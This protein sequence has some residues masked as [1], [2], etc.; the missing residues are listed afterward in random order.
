MGTYSQATGGTKH[1]VIDPGVRAYWSRERA[2]HGEKV[3]LSV[4]ARH[5]KDGTKVVVEIR[6]DGA[7]PSSPP[8]ATLDKGY[9]LQKGKCAI[10]YTIKWDKASLGKELELETDACLFYFVAKMDD[11]EIAQ[12]SENLLYVHLE[13]VVSG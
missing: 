4:E 13:Y 7:D 11:L 1:I 2:W 12:R 3:K 5:A 9:A 10:D 6:E 8:V